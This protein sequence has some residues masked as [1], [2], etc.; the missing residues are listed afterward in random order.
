MV[1]PVEQ[2]VCQAYQ[3]VRSDDGLQ[4]YVLCAST[5]DNMHWQCGDH[6]GRLSRPMPVV[7]TRRYIDVTVVGL[8]MT[9]A[10]TRLMDDQFLWHGSCRSRLHTMIGLAVCLLDKFPVS[11]SLDIHSG[12]RAERR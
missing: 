2:R 10:F 5:T 12:V 4:R 1:M 7:L 9:L 11:W 6:G 3:H 8:L